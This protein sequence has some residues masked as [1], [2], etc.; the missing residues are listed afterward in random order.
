MSRK[1]KERTKRLQVKLTPE[2]FDLLRQLAKDRG[3]YVAE[4]VRR[5]VFSEVRRE[6]K[7]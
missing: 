5:C 6:K 4:F 2:E 3:L 7:G 1:V